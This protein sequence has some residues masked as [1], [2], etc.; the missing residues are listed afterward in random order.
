MEVSNEQPAS[1]VETPNNNEQEH[2]DEGME[3]S[4][5]YNYDANDE[6]RHFIPRGRGGYR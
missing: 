6:Y 2:N 3:E 4:D 1:A 5:E